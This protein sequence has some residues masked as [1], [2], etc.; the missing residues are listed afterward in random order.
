MVNMSKSSVLEA[1]GAAL[2]YIS[3]N[4]P[5]KIP[6]TGVLLDALPAYTPSIPDLY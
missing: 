6:Y 4:D 5:Q 1:S 2:L 3:S